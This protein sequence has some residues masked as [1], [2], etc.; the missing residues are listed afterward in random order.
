MCDLL[1]MNFNKSVTATFSLKGFKSRG[2]LNPDGWGIAW[3]PDKSVQVIKE[4]VKATQSNLFSDVLKDMKMESEIFIGH[5]RRG[6]VGEPAY[7]NTHPFWRELN[8]KAYVFAHNGSR[9]NDWENSSQLGKFKPPRD[10][11]SKRIFKALGDTDSESIFCYIL[12]C[13]E[14]QRIGNWTEDSFSWL[15]EKFTEV[16]KYCTSNFAMSDGE[17]LFVYHDSG[18]HNGM[19][20]VF[21]HPPYADVKLKDDE[22]EVLFGAT[23]DP[24]LRGFIVTTLSKTK[25]PNPKYLTN[26]NWEPIEPGELMVFKKGRMVY[27][28]KRQTIRELSRLT[29]QELKVLSVIR[30]NQHKISI[31]EITNKSGYSVRE[32]VEALRSLREKELIKHDTTDTVQ[33]NHSNANYFTQPSKRN[34]IYWFL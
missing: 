19:A 27:S 16:N 22:E 17:H 26:E 5:V 6:S 12:N 24:E 34:E 25:S 21:R 14:E 28:S 15:L 4:P 29:E 10:T 20:L 7:R 23:K 11:D 1:A 30:H 33:W 31:N 13:I 18:G 9:K 8:G 3:Y 2:T 32:V